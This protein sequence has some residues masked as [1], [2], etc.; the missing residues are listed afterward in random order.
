MAKDVGLQKCTNCR[1][2]RALS[3][4]LHPTTLGFGQQLTCLLQFG[5]LDVLD[6]A[7]WETELN[8]HINTSSISPVTPC[9]S[10]LGI[11]FSTFCATV[12]LLQMDSRVVSGC[13]QH[14]GKCALLSGPHRLDQVSR[15]TVSMSGEQTVKNLVRAL[16]LLHRQP[17]CEDR[18]VGHKPPWRRVAARR[19]LA[20]GLL[21]LFELM[22]NT[23]HLQDA[24]QTRK[25]PNNQL[26]KHR[27]HAGN[28]PEEGCLQPDAV[29]PEAPDGLV[30]WE[31]VED[32]RRHRNEGMCK[33]NK[34]FPDA[35]AITISAG[36]EA[37]D[38]VLVGVHELHS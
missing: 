35:A 4:F 33:L 17:L 12:R 25:P 16:Q 15:S 10:S 37:A 11:V 9:S 23:F 34:L 31:I 18:L 38:V 6:A 20:L 28:C 19:P 26:R 27:A 7:T 1:G 14:P 29:A 5:R 30:I 22:H 32:D 24:V 21:R 36:L 2:A 3:C 13:N 8:K